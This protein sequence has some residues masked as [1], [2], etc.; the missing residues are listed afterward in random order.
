MNFDEMYSEY[1]NMS[2][3]E[4][5]KIGQE[6]GAALIDFMDS[7]YDDK[8]KSFAV[9]M[10]IY[11]SFV[12]IDL[13]INQEEYDMFRNITA[14]SA[15][16]NE[17]ADAVKQSFDYDVINELD[18]MI[19]ANVKIKDLVIKLGLAICAY[20]GNISEEEKSLIERYWN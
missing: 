17:F 1:L 15:S 10:K 20:D 13:N 16:F 5:L 3:E 6:N 14:V 18:S 9:F 11:G 7:L 2:K 4:L 12:A 8:D 19:D